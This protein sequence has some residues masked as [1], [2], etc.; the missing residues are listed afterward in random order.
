MALFAFFS[1]YVCLVFQHDRLLSNS[2]LSTL[3]ILSLHVGRER[4]RKR[5]NEREREGERKREHNI[6]LVGN[7]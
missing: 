7:L 5:E 1:M 4:E 2:I 6:I 3:G